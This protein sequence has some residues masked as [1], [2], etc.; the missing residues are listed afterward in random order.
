LPID[1]IDVHSNPYFKKRVWQF[2]QIAVFIEE[3]KYYISPLC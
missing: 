1:Q 3:I 2:Y